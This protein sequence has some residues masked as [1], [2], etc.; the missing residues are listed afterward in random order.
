MNLHEVDPIELLLHM[1]IVKAKHR[2][3]LKRPLLLD[4]DVQVIQRNVWTDSSGTSHTNYAYL[5]G[6]DKYWDEFRPAYEKV[7]RYCY[8]TGFMG[9][10]ILAV[11]DGIWTTEVRGTAKLASFYRWDQIREDHFDS[12]SPWY[13]EYLIRPDT[14]QEHPSRHM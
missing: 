14:E 7:Y 13:L 6:A 3:T 11:H 12:G 4:P 1:G 5:H 10:I 9:G 2:P 8:N